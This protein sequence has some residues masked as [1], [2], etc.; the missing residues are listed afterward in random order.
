MN[1]HVYSVLSIRRTGANAGHC[2]YLC[3][4]ILCIFSRAIGV[5]EQIRSGIHGR[6]FNVRVV[7]R[8]EYFHAYLMRYILEVKRRLHMALEERGEVEWKKSYPRVWIGLYIS[9]LLLTICILHLLNGC[10][11]YQQKKRKRAPKT[12]HETQ[13]TQYNEQRTYSDLPSSCPSFDSTSGD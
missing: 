8:L 5:V 2:T 9:G 11:C 13:N 10:V 7:Q 6:S 3:S 1:P 4:K 12:H